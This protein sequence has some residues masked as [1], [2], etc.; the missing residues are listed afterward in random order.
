MA[1][2]Q[3]A[4]PRRR[5][6][7]IVV[8]LTVVL[9]LAVVVVIADFGLRAYAE[10]RA[11][12]EISSSLPDTVDGNIDVTIGGFS[13]LQQ[14]L[15]GTLDQVTI[16]APQLSVDGV[17]V[18]AHVVATA[19]PTDLSQPVGA[20]SARLSLSEDAVNS[21]IQ[22]PGA[23]TLTLDN[24][25]VGYDG[26]ISVLG[27]R[28]QYL[29]TAGV[30]V[31]ADSVVLTP[32]TAKLTAGSTVVDASSALN[33]I[34]DESI[35]LCVADRLPRGVE[36]TSLSVTPGSATVALDAS[37]FTIDETSLRTMGTCP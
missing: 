30:S 24:Q 21:V 2:G 1:R 27:L 4:A 31:T 35:P 10:D 3:S 5:R 19:V 18:E 32:E 7:G 22:V 17:P 6:R 11:K 29:V 8:V 23:A 15:S 25:A 37:D 34:L 36:L 9:L 26:S 13:F 14:Y 12:A 33:A 16:D 28:L 20:I